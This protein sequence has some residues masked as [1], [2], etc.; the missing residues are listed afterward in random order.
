[1]QQAIKAPEVKTPMFL[2]P[3]KM[4][5]NQKP[6]K[7][8]IHVKA[9][10]QIPQ[11]SVHPLD[12]QLTEGSEILTANLAKRIE[13][14]LK[15]RRITKTAFA[16]ILQISQASLAT[17]LS[18]PKPWDRLRGT[19]NNYIKIFNWLQMSEEEKM[20]LSG[21]ARTPYTKFT[22]AQRAHMEQVFSTCRYPNRKTF[23]EM[24]NE[25]KLNVHTIRDHFR[26]M[27]CK[28]RTQN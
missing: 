12:L 11:D 27:R 16:D 25:L 19:Q 22:D 20:E 7:V 15:E 9:D 23:R 24:A 14:E 26:K 4:L 13:F 28:A 17:C 10:P 1:M 6:V 8:N 2:Y 21:G 3:V 18:K 5:Q